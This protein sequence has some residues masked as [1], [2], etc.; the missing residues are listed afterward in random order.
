MEATS[1]PGELSEAQLAHVIANKAQ[2]AY[3]RGDKLE[4]RRE[5]L[6]SWGEYLNGED[7]TATQ[8]A[9]PNES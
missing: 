5:L 2:A 8:G 4:R 7:T 9:R 6:A 3:E 1:Y